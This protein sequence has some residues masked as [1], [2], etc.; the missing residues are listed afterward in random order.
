MNPS[1]G[2]IGLGLVGSALAERMRA[3]GYPVHGHD[4]DPP[5]RLAF[6]AAGGV[7]EECAAD[8]AR[9]CR[10]LVLSLP[11]TQIVQSVLAEM[12]AALQPGTIILDTTT[13]EPD[14]MA[15]F[16]ESLARRGIHYL[17]AT[18][19]GSSAQVRT[20]DVI[21]MLGGETAAVK[22]CEELIRSFARQ[23][24]H[25]GPCGAGARMKLVVNLLL[26]L[27]RAVLAEGLSFARACGVDPAVALDVLRAG[28]AYSRVMDTK[29][30]KMLDRDFAPQ[31]RLGQHLKDVNLIIAEAAKHG[32]KTP[33]SELHR[34]LLEEL[35]AAGYGSE[36]NA[37][38]LRAFS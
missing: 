23:S 24:F 18:I 16:G 31:A 7:A 26:G 35:D 22:A 12:D 21:V 6:A 8:V 10:L 37:A 13:G 30:K 3:A 1:I 4:V 19:A 28:P 27:H 29:G 20:G 32:A 33:L 9:S 11:T 2:L 38:I 14:A 36:D 17:D 5:A 34:K 15:A 25:L